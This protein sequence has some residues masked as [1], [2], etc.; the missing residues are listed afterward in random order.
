MAG[1]LVASF[2]RRHGPAVS[3]RADLE[4]DAGDNRVT[5]NGYRVK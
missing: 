4:L 2:L 5:T 1:R 3:I